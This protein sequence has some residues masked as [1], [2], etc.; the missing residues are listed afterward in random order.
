MITF[1]AR[2]RPSAEAGLV[3]I[4]ALPAAEVMVARH[5]AM[6]EKRRQAHGQ[7]VGL[8]A[9]VKEMLPGGLYREALQLLAKHSSN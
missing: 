5:D 8:L 1:L 6:R 3:R 9:Y 7:L 2:G 4:T